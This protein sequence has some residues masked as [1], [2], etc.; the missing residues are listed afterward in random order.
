M[1]PLPEKFGNTGETPTYWHHGDNGW[2]G[3]LSP[4]QYPKVINPKNNRLW[5]ANSRVVGGV[6]LEK[7]GNGG[8]AL[9]ARA[10][11]I[12]QNLFAFD[13]FNEES[14]LAIALDDRATF[15]TPWLNFL[16]TT[17]LNDDALTD[18]VLSI[19]PQFKQVKSLLSENK[20]LSAS[21][22]S[23]SYRLVRNFRI[24]VRDLVFSE[25]NNTLENTDDIYNFSSIRAQ[26]EVPLWQLVNQQP[27]NFLMRPLKSWQAVFNQ[28]LQQTI[29]DMIYLNGNNTQ[30]LAKATWGQQNTSEI[31]HPLSQSI[32]FIGQWLNM[33][34]K[35][36]SGDSYMPKVQ[37][38]S[39]GASERMV[40]SP[41]HE[42][43]GIFHMPT[44]QAGHP[45]S[46]YY[47]KGHTDWEQG[48]A[49]AFLPGETKYKLTLLSY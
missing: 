25:L 6:M 32:P 45:W 41:G 43:T 2:R 26:I 35:A 39:F 46:P 36:L 1:G 18:E 16:L 34:A 12:R 29:D 8:Y 24:N 21:I 20:E 40:V 33:P 10:K 49:S 38:K 14:L 48:V 5:T 28:A 13:T 37:G 4:A 22:D 42:E 31:H 30:T 9:G 11:Q 23:V 19:H 7:I 3:Y 17:I 47:G 44:S 15:L 27:D